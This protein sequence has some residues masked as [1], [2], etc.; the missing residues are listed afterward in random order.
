MHEQQKTT[1]QSAVFGK[2]SDSV[3][4]FVFKTYRQFHT[5]LI[6]MNKHNPVK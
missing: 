6:E 4:Y 3:G 1:Q 2:I 5:I